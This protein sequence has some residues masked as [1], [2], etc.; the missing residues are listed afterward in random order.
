MKPTPP[1]SHHDGSLPQCALQARPVGTKAV[2]LRTS[3][4]DISRAES[5]RRSWIIL[6]GSLRVGK[7]DDRA[8][9]LYEWLGYEVCGEELNSSTFPD[10]TPVAEG[11]C[12][13]GSGLASQQVSRFRRELRSAFS[14]S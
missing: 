7:E 10:G 8:R 11:C 3:K 2:G 12:G 9:R 5:A 14:M 6:R 4:R 13:T 1:T